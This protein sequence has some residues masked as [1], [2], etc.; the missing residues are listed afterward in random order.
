M[1]NEN[2]IQGV[3]PLDNSQVNRSLKY[4]RKYRR[5]QI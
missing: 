4:K 3:K 5:N 2:T 1:I